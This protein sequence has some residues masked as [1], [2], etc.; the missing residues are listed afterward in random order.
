MHIRCPVCLPRPCSIACNSVRETSGGLAAFAQ[1]LTICLVPQPPVPSLALSA[2]VTDL[3][4]GPTQLEGGRYTRVP[5]LAVA[6]R[7]PSEGWV[8]GGCC[9]RYCSASPCC[10]AAGTPCP[11]TTS[12]LQGV[13]CTGVAGTCL[14]G[15]QLAQ[16]LSCCCHL[17]CAAAAT[18]GLRDNQRYR[19][20]AVLA[21]T[22]VGALASLDA[23]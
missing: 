22:A 16:S 19:L 23:K 7:T 14:A 21:P 20:V 9:L 17:G 15:C 4:A 5:W 8:A 13:G 12:L 18:Y 11:C 2:A 3:L 10:L 1:M 6:H